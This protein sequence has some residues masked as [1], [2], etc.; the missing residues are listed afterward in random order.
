[1]FNKNK[2]KYIDISAEVT[3]EIVPY[4]EPV[5][6]HKAEPKKMLKNE[7]LYTHDHKVLYEKSNEVITGLFTE[8]LHSGYKL[9]DIVSVMKNVI[10]DNE[11]NIQVF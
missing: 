9:S 5:K 6:S 10:D 1:M 11:G 8:F 2:S 7:I 3:G 4:V